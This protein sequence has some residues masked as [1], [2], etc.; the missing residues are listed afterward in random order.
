VSF[1]AKLRQ[2]NAAPRHEGEVVSRKSPAEISPEWIAEAQAVPHSLNAFGLR[3]L[4][5][6]ASR[7]PKQNIFISPL[8]VF[9]ALAMTETG[10]GGETKAAIRGALCLPADASQA[11][12]NQAA[13]AL[14]KKLR[15]VGA[16]E[17]AIANALWVDTRAAVRAEF[18]QD[19]QKVYDA[20]VRAIDLSQP[21]AVTDIN[22]WVAEKTRGKIPK[23][24][25]PA[26]IA[27]CPAVITNAVYFSGKYSYP[28]RKEATQPR[29]FHLGGGGEKIVP[30]MRQG[31]RIGDYRRGKKFEAAV[32]GYQGSM[33]HLYMLLPAPGVP[34]EKILTEE[35]LE[36]LLVP[37]ESIAHELA[38][39]RFTLDFEC[40]LKGPLTR[41][42]MGV[43][44]E[45]PAADFTPMGSP[46]FYI[47]EVIHKTRLEVDEEGTVAAAAVAEMVALGC[48]P[49]RIIENRTLVFDR[50]FAVLLRHS[51]SG[52]NLFAG[53]VNDPQTN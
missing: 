49:R 16:A 35:S 23:I 36:E 27:A 9:L 50:P 41:M 5:E 48:A 17:L 38:M 24:V 29:P 34:P 46:L 21:S 33:M 44:F 28:F 32:I 31:G 3:L 40:R 15:L 52:A 25:T 19:C 1:W 11:A 42:G 12:L 14:M 4:Q 20:A 2:Q 10:A 53:V 43:A 37:H 18:V 22:H 13:V 51:I 6:E 30:M 39:P 8:S 47:G 7:A 45:Y 26:D